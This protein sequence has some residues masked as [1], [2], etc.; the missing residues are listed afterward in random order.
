MNF[1]LSLFL[2]Y[3]VYETKPVEEGSCPLA[4]QGKETGRRGS[5]WMNTVSVIYIFR[6]KS[7]ERKNHS[8]MKILKCEI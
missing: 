1:L 6:E 5:R 4:T 3:F 2:S 7:Y 8:E